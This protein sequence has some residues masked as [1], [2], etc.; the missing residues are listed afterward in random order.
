MR[1]G[2]HALLPFAIPWMPNGLHVWTFHPTTIAREHAKSPKRR[3]TRCGIKAIPKASLNHAKASGRVF[4]RAAAQDCLVAVV[5]SARVGQEPLLSAVALD[6][7]ALLHPMPNARDDVH[8][9]EFE[10]SE[11]IVGCSRTASQN[12]GSLRVRNRVLGSI[13]SAFQDSGNMP[14]TA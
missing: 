7:R 1:H 14:S 13:F 11:H 5:A 4:G 3:L 2:W 10:L 9:V 6:L 12:S 8:A